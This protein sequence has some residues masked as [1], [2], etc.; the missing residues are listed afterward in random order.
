[1]SKRM[2]VTLTLILALAGVVGIQNAAAQENSKQQEVPSKPL[3]EEDVQAKPMNSYNVEFT[4]NEMD[5]GKKVNSRSYSMLVLADD[6]PK[7]T[8]G[9]RLRVS[10]N[11]P[12]P[13]TKNSTGGDVY[14]YKDLGM[15][16]DYRLMPLGGGKI[17]ISTVWGYTSLAS[18]QGHDPQA[19][20]TRQVHAEVK[21][22][23]PL[24]KPTVISD[25]DDVAST[26]HYVFEVK[27]TKVT[28]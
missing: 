24:D 6:Q 10:S 16:I 28:Q 20:V 15:D 7:W 23:V 17:G 21:A 5:N 18:D 4:V 8:D 9:R 3:K 2:V 25:V 13:V 12:V 19:P 11:V 14:Q 1:M 22:I 26:A 27:V